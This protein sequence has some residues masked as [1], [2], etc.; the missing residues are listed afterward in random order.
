MPKSDIIIARY[1]N[2]G[3]LEFVEITSEVKKNLMQALK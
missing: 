2:I 3:F 1:P